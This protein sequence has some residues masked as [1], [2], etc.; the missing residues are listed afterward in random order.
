MPRQSHKQ[1]ALQLLQRQMLLF[2]P[3][4]SRVILC[5]LSALHLTGQE[6]TTV[7]LPT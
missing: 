4:R 6:V 3:I 1:A 7:Q 2:G 5:L